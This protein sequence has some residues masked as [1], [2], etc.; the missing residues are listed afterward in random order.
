MKRIESVLNEIVI[1]LIFIG[2]LS[3]LFNPLHF[4]MPRTVWMTLAAGFAVVFTLF[5]SL[6]WSERPRDEREEFH[7]MLADRYGFLL[8]AAL[9]VLIIIYQSY[10]RELETWPV[11]VLAAMVLAKLAG[12]IYGR[13]RR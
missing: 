5:V 4:W 3:L 12:L 9:L 8:G 1:S 7:R 6:V 2:V 13:V 11:L 10:N